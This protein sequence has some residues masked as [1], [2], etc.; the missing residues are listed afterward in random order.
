MSK[1]VSIHS[2]SSFFSNCMLLSIPPL[3]AR[4]DKMRSL[5]FLNVCPYSILVIF[6]LGSSG[7]KSLNCSGE[8]TPSTTSKLSVSYVLKVR[9]EAMWCS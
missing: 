4:I 7:A 6:V 3:K 5:E 1:R 2:P 9:G 8:M